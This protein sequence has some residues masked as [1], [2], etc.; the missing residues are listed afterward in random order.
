MN[1]L[2]VIGERSLDDHSVANVNQKLFIRTLS[3]ELQVRKNHP[4]NK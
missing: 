4:T 3:I 2:M 1:V